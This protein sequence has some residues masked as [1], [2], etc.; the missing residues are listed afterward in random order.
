MC[1]ADPAAE[2][3]VCAVLLGAEFLLRSESGDRTVSAQDFFVDALTTA[4]QEDEL[5]KEVR[6]P[7]ALPNAGYCF[8]EIARRHGDFA[9]VSVA[10]MVMSDAE[11]FFDETAVALGGVGPRPHRCRLGDLASKI[12]LSKQ[13]AAEL[14]SH[15][16]DRLDPSSDLQ[17]NA[18][19]R[20]SIAGYLIE[21]ALMIGLSRAQGR[22]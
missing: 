7:A 13:S 9:L 8:L 21:R 3:P 1:H 12:A 22:I 14:A 10:C 11:G 4:T 20:R 17:A 2:L 19:Y 16:A 18:E 15:I 5:V 6:I